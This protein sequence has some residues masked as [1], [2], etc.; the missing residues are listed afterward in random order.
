MADL[1]MTE[2][3]RAYEAQTTCSAEWFKHPFGLVYTSGIKFVAETCEA[4]WLIDLVASHQPTIRAKLKQHDLSGFQVW[5][6]WIL[7]GGCPTCRV[8]A[9]GCKT[10]GGQVDPWIIDA[11]SDT[12][13]HKGGEDGPA[14]VLLARQVI[15]FSSFPEALAPFEFWVEGDTALLKGEH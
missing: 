9:D 2:T 15:G 1:T 5:R 8:W 4:Y 14:S 6:L 3:V 12:P 11:W 13:E 10:C 7:T